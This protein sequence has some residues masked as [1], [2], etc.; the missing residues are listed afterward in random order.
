MPGDGFTTRVYA[1]S[2]DTIRKHLRRRYAEG[3]QMAY[4]YYES[5]EAI[6]AGLQRLRQWM[7]E[8][9]DERTT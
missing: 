8:E 2:P 3:I 7:Q 9:D 4:C 1:Y 5:Q 6:R